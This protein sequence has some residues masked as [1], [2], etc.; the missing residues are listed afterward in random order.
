MASELFGMV[1]AVNMGVSST[2]VDQ[3][4][5]H[6]F[7]GAAEALSQQVFRFVTARLAGEAGSLGK[8]PSQSPESSV[9]RDGLGFDEAFAAL[10]SLLSER[11]L[12]IDDPRALAFVGHSPAISAT[13]ADIALS[14]AGVL[15]DWWIQGAG[16]IEAENAALAWLAELAGF[17]RSAGG[18]FLSGGT[19][20]NLTALHV[21]RHSWRARGGARQAAVAATA[22]AHSS[23]RLAA[24]V[25]DV[26]IVP[27]PLDERGRMTAAALDAALAGREVFAVAS[28]AGC[29]N[30]GAIDELD[31]IAAI[32]RERG[33]WL[34]VDGAYGGGALASE[35][36]RPQ[37]AG[38]E[39]A[40][41]LVVDPH[42]WL[43]T[44]VDCSA[45]L[46]RDPELARAACT[47]TADYLDP[48]DGAVDW[49]PS[50]YGIHMT[51]RARGLP[52]WFALAAHGTHAFEAAIDACLEV[53]RE[54]ADLIEQMPELALIMQPELSVVLFQRIG[55]SRLEY[56]VWSQALL[57]S[58]LGFVVPTS[59]AGEPA[60]RFCFIN[61]NTTLEHVAAI[62]ETLKD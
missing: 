30:T 10:S 57:A 49:N 9:T 52:L 3:A 39:S 31:G 38:I 60:L 24:R 40:D 13:L 46:Y 17:P 37:F 61:P 45:L 21:A 8:T 5:M 43:F 32:C 42:K 14:A 22:E 15:A 36:A 12:R 26:E 11:C 25:L 4:G 1:G 34:H 20:A 35:A 55:W 51:R 2:L 54:T 44:P 53:A 59:W 58:G 18:V 47:Q 48:V 7:D 56:E 19:A 28:S 33:I 41:S 23:I 62:L 50:D 16:A 6:R 27:V 29:T